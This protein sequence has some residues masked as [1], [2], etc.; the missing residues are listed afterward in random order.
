M[1]HPGLSLEGGATRLIPGTLRVSPLAAE[2][3]LLTVSLSYPVCGV[4]CIGAGATLQVRLGDKAWRRD[5]DA[6]RGNAGPGP[7][8]RASRLCT[9]CVLCHSSAQAHKDEVAQLHSTVSAIWQV[10]SLRFRVAQ[11]PRGQAWERQ[12]GDSMGPTVPF[13][14]S[15]HTATTQ[16]A[17][18]A[19]KAIPCP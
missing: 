3:A 2:Y 5:T 17:W 15:C 8:V 16:R 19:G 7:T 6:L 1:S 4:P 9:D 13:T 11:R 10:G 18:G 12:S 14:S